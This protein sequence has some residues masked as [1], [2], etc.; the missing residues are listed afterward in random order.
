MAP[1]YSTPSAS[2]ELKF[3][4]IIRFGIGSGYLTE[5]IDSVKR[6]NFDRSV[7]A[8]NLHFK[9]SNGGTTTLV[10]TF[11]TGTSCN[12]L[13]ITNYFNEDGSVQRKA[14]KF[15]FYNGMP[16]NLHATMPKNAQ[17]EQI[18]A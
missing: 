13:Y 2:P 15:Y 3:R 9:R 17:Q 18:Y 7:Y 6:V 14:P 10:I 16:I 11:G 5:D 8:L 1:S 4:K 12:V